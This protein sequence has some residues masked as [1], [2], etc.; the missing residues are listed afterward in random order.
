[1]AHCT[2]L[3]CS[4]AV[5]RYVKILK[6]NIMDSFEFSYAICRECK[7]YG[8][9]AAPALR[10]VP[11]AGVPYDCDS[12]MHYGTETWSL[13]QGRPTMESRHPG[14]DLRWAEHWSRL[15]TALHCTG[16]GS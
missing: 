1:L 8:E 4:T 5:H 7:D 10:M 6:E 12:I 3:H 14:C 2:A 13:G 15:L 9:P 16:A 11:H